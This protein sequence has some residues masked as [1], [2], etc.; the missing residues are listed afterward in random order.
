MPGGLADDKVPEDFD[1]EALA[2][3]IKMEHTNNPEIATE[4]AMD[5]LTEDPNYYAKLK[6][7]EKMAA[8]YLCQKT[9]LQM[10]AGDK[11][12]ALYWVAVEGAKNLSV[13]EYEAR[14]LGNSAHSG[15]FLLTGV[16]HVQP[17]QAVW[18]ASFPIRHV[19]SISEH[20]ESGS[21]FFSVKTKGP[22]S[23]LL[24]MAL[25]DYTVENT[26][27]KALGKVDYV[28]YRT[29][30]GAVIVGDIFVSSWGYGQTRVDYYQV[31]KVTPAMVAMRE[32]DKKVTRSTGSADY[33]V[34]VSNKFTGPVINK[35]VTS[36]SDGR[37]MVRLTS[38]SW[39]FKWDG[40]PKYQTASGWGH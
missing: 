11:K 9:A 37:P 40:Q 6:T 27:M 33:I 30:A 25:S 7:I 32:I 28:P 16:L 29:A 12:K 24:D 2:Q 31:V 34:P 19:V 5:H 18:S 14:D 8:A 35:K 39:A 1:P 38:Y 13:K 20:A 3:G 21:I 26:V 10:T 15:D 4:I 23:S 22:V 36:G 17:E